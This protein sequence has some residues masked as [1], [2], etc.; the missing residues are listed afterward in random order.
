MQ[1]HPLQY[2]V[3]L[4]LFSLFLLALFFSPRPCHDQRGNLKYSLTPVLGWIP[5]PVGL[6]GFALP[7][8]WIFI[9]VYCCCYRWL[10][11]VGRHA[12]IIIRL[13]NSSFFIFSLTQATTVVSFVDKKHSRRKVVWCDWEGKPSNWTGPLP[14]LHMVCQGLAFASPS[15]RHFKN[16]QIFLAGNL[17][18]RLPHCKLVLKYYLKAPEIFRY[19]PKAL[20]CKISSFRLLAHLRA[21]VTILMFLPGW[22][23]R[24]LHHATLLIISCLKPFWK[25]VANGSFLVWGEVGKENTPHLVVP[26][27]VE[28]TKPRVCHD[29]RFLNCWIKDWRW[30]NDRRSERNLCNW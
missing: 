26:I 17:T 7:F 18:K 1:F 24:T 2:C 6:A 4:L 19:I 13:V 11:C 12:L 28:P 20:N 3:S 9:F 21:F 10:A 30:R 8:P 29:E 27:T 15:M 14:S 23:F 5:S 22:S 16:P 25:W